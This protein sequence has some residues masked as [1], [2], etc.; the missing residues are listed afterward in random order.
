MK[1]IHTISTNIPSKLWEDEFSILRYGNESFFYESGCK[2]K[3]ICITSEEEIKEGDYVPWK[4]QIF[5]VDSYNAYSGTNNITLVYAKKYCK[6]IILTTDTDLIKDGAQAIDD[7]FLD[8]FIKNQSCEKVEVIKGSFDLN[9]TETMLLREN[10]VPESTFNTYKII[11]PKEESKTR[12]FGTKNDKQFWS[13]KPKQLQ[14]PK[15]EM[16]EEVAEK[17]AEHQLKGISDKTSKFECVND[18]IA[19]AKWQ[20]ERMYSEE[21]ECVNMYLDDLKV[22]RKSEE[23]QEYS[24][25][26]RIKLLGSRYL[27]QMSDVESHYLSKKE[28]MYSE[29]EVLKIID[30]VKH[31]EYMNG[32]KAQHKFLSSEILEEFK[33]RNVTQFK[34]K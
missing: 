4:N 24:I 34:K 20:T 18:F 33:N 28:T 23:G 19:G 1:N 32:T 25:V 2:W 10:Y 8:W 3:N 5:K 31:L 7:E 29:E 14:E 16:V 27:K 15:R 17:Y 22:Q 12:V 13:D 26:G 6:K 21:S 9:P 11:I 30:F